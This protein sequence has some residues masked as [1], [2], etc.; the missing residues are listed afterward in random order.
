MRHY[1]VL[2]FP[3]IHHIDDVP[4]PGREALCGGVGPSPLTPPW[5]AT[6]AM[7]SPGVARAGLEADRE[8]PAGPGRGRGTRVAEPR[9]MPALVSKDCLR[10]QP[11]KLHYLRE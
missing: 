4:H 5:P 7:I 1:T 2:D 8:G 3:R 9:P 10:A 11:V 6:F